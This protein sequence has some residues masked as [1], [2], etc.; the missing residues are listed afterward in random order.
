MRKSAVIAS[1]AT[2]IAL[3]AGP[4]FSPADAGTPDAVTDATYVVDF[5]ATA[6]FG[7]AMNSKGDVAGS[8]YSD[9]GCGSSCLPPIDP[10]VW[11]DG[12]R[13]VL[14]G[15]PGLSGVYPMSI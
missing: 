6:A 5:V 15:L 12:R 9:P 3:V 10:V 13:I 14:P 4:G 1:G 7:V 2:A 11:R 8:S